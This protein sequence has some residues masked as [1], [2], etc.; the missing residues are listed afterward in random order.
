M[1]SYSAQ[2]AALIQPH[3]LASEI[4]YI[5][6]GDSHL[7]RVARSWTDR[8]KGARARE[9]RLAEDTERCAWP[10]AAELCEAGDGV[11]ANVHFGE[12]AVLGEARFVKA[13]R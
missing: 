13:P 5:R 11:G 10:Q 8:R 1:N 6:R 12:K 3:D 7:I 2:V 4:A 9:G